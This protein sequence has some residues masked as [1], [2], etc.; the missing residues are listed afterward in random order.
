MAGRYN[1]CP[2]WKLDLSQRSGW[3]LRVVKLDRVSLS[4][5]IKF[6]WFFV[7]RESLVDI[8]EK[9]GFSWTYKKKEHCEHVSANMICGSESLRVSVCRAYSHRWIQY[10]F[11]GEIDFDQ[12]QQRLIVLGEYSLA[13]AMAAG[14][15]KRIELAVDVFGMHTSEVLC[16]SAG[17]RSGKPVP[18]GE[19]T[20][21]SIYLGSRLGM[22]QFVIYDKNQE[23]SDKGK[24]HGSGNLLRIE[25]RLYKIQLPLANFAELFSAYDPFM[26]LYVVRRQSIELAGPKIKCWSMLIGTCIDYGV[27]V[28]LKYFPAQKRSL[29]N[30]MKALNMKVR[31]GPLDFLPMLV[32]LREATVNMKPVDEDGAFI[33]I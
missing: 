32:R 12:F 3:M 21:W 17:V 28:G 11:T 10:E 27:W 15:T 25:L 23:L 26:G 16:H 9:Y 20:G 18:N 1:K 14:T 2:K 24:P 31:P 5:S 33:A 19:R 13:N 7:V 4:L 6:E 8:S 29:L 22:R 30:A